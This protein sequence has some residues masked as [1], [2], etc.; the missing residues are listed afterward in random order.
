MPVSSLE[1][2]AKVTRTIMQS[3]VVGA[4][5]GTMFEKVWVKKRWI[6]VIPVFSQ[7]GRYSRCQVWPSGL[8]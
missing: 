7:K 4:H 6:P 1:D 5:D 3:S 2:P 8:V